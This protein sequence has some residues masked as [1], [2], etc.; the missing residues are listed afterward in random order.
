MVLA[1]P[2]VSTTSDPAAAT[3]QGRRPKLL[4]IAYA[5]RPDVGSE[6]GAGWAFAR[7]AAGIGETWVLHRPR[8]GDTLTAERSRSIPEAASLHLVPVRQGWLARRPPATADYPL[9]RLEYLL[10]QLR[11]LRVA[12]RIARREGIDVVWHVSWSTWWLGSLGG[13]VGPPFVWGPVGGGVG[14]PWPLLATLGPRGIAVELARWLVLGTARWLNPMARLGWSRAAL[15]L[16]Q[17]A[18]TA[19]RLPESTRDRTV[20]FHHIALEEGDVPPRERA[21]RPADRPPT[22]LFAGRLVAWK[23]SGL[24]VDAIARLDGWRLLVVGVGPEESRLRARVAAAGLA[25]RVVFL[26]Q[27]ER[28]ELLRMMRDEA[29]VFL[30]PSLHEEGGWVV[31]E[32]LA[33]GLPVVCIDRGGPPAVGGRG[34]P[35]GSAPVTADRLGRA[36]REVLDDPTSLV[37]APTLERRRTAAVDLLRSRGL[38][39]GPVPDR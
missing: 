4:V 32:A 13:L 11:A 12:R 28:A 5:C 3:T 26:G 24:A 29:D 35:L 16:A 8:P 20:V 38:I 6:A 7:I 21:P 31:G 33:C 2:D 36:V 27:V 1:V 25:D 19:R 22:A 9:E 34:V 18:D 39:D 10:W 15:I 14:P 17:N 30:F 37:P 23:G